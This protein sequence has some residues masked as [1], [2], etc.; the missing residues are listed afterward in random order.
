MLTL[1]IPDPKPQ[2]QPAQSEAC[3]QNVGGR[4]TSELQARS[5]VRAPSAGWGAVGAPQGAVL[6]RPCS[7]ET[8]FTGKQRGTLQE[9]N[10]E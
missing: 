7:R 6:H 1:Q 4:D 2:V 5:Q 9:G 10:S 8:I 3:S